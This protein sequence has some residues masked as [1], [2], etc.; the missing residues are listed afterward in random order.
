MYFLTGPFRVISRL[1][2][3]IYKISHIQKKFTVITNAHKLQKGYTWPQE[4]EEYTRIN[5]PQNLDNLVPILPLAQYV[6]REIFGSPN[7]L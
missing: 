1:R 3:A 6:S 2:N 7:P 4:E 5:S